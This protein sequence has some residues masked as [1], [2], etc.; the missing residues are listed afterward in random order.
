MTRTDCVD[1]RLQGSRIKLSPKP[2]GS[3]NIVSGASRLKLVQ[4][5]KSLLRERHWRRFGL[6]GLL[7]QELR[8]QRALRGSR[9]LQT[10]LQGTTHLSTSVS[11]F[12]FYRWSASD[13]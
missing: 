1:G 9:E 13:Q 8:K 4:K 5:P 6:G 3:R 7:M 2:S 12:N 11:R 10:I